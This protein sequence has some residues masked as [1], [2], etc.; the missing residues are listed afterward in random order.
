MISFIAGLD[1][2]TLQFVAAVVMLLT[3]LAA[4]I[5]WRISAAGSYAHR[6]AIG[7]AMIC[8]GLIAGALRGRL[9]DLVAIVGGNALMAMGGVMIANGLALFCRGRG[10]WPV[11]GIGAAIA[12]SFCFF[13][14]VHPSLHV[15]IVLIALL[16]AAICLRMAWLLW[17]DAPQGMRVVQQPL[18]ALIGAQCLFYLLHATTA[19]VPA[20]AVRFMDAPVV[21]N[22]LYLNALVIFI[23]LLFGFTALA[24][25]RLQLSLEHTAH[26]DALTGALNRHALD[27]EL[28]NAA[29]GRPLAPLSVVMLDLDH[30]KQLNDRFGHQAGDEALRLFADAARQNL[31][32]SD[33]LGRT[34]GEEFC[35]VLP[36]TDSAAACGI[37]ERLRQLVETIAIPGAPAAR[38]TVSAGVATSMASG[39]REAL[40][41]T[42]DE[43]LYA[44]KRAGRNRVV[45][46]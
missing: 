33:A 32:Q 24:N 6:W 9:P 28:R 12:A 15:R 22:G 30:F 18:A 44:A 35:L 7:Y 46:V 29:A 27:A 14:Y 8:A 5:L 36:R 20:Q 23:C 42:A 41:K 38:L 4:L 16:F 21:Y 1:T 45:A 34:G 3:L 43:A 40:L 25:R 39:D 10:T 37:A 19:L 17:F 31:R 13:V 2:A 26:H 11:A